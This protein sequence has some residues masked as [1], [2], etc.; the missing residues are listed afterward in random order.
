MQYPY[1][2]WYLLVVKLV[3]LKIFSYALEKKNSSSLKNGM[4]EIE[5]YI[6]KLFCFR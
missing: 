2:N 1:K 5:F 4:V 3:K 6:K